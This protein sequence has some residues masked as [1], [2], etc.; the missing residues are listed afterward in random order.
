MSLLD[1]LEEAKRLV[2]LCEGVPEITKARMNFVV[3]LVTIV[4]IHARARLKQKFDDSLL[5]GEFTFN[6]I[7]TAT[8]DDAEQRRLIREMTKIRNK[9]VH[10]GKTITIEHERIDRYYLLARTMLLTPH[11]ENNE[12]GHKD[13]LEASRQE[14]QETA[15]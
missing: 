5:E 10:E 13:D 7:V 1:E 3:N 8:L 11:R 9:F 4:E 2:T 6:T 15:N 12:S 14:P